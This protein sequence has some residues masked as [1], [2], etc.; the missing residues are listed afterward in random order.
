MVEK[1]I[2]IMASIHQSFCLDWKIGWFSFVSRSCCLYSNLTIDKIRQAT[3]CCGRMLTWIDE[4]TLGHIQKRG[5][6]KYICN[7]H[8]G[9]YPFG[10]WT[11]EVKIVCYNEDTWMTHRRG[12]SKNKET[13]WMKLW[14]LNQSTEDSGCEV[15]NLYQRTFEER[16]SIHLSKT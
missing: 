7:D 12:L 13:F 16:F 14:I 5:F 6:Q 8:S 10:K 2:F 15:S 4:L 9:V 3:F 1:D 11:L